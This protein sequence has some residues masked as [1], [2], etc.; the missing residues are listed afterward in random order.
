MSKFHSLKVIDVHK[1][2]DDCKSVA[3]EIPEELKADFA[4]KQGQYLTLRT[5]IEGEDVRRN[6]SLCSSPID[7]E[8]R[9]AIK[10]VPNGKFSTFANEVLKKGDMLDVM[11][12]MGHFY[13]ELDANNKKHYIAFAAG[14]GITPM[15]SIM[16]TVLHTEPESIFTL[17]YGN[18]NTQSIIFHEDIEGLKNKYMTRMSVYYLLSRD[19]LEEPILNGRIDS[20]KCNDLFNGLIDV[21][22]GDE[23]FICG[24]EEMINNVREVLKTAEVSEEKVHFELFTSPDGKLGE[25][26]A[27]EIATEDQGKVCAVTVTV[28]GKTFEF[29]LA[30][31]GENLLDAA[32]KEGADLPYACKGGVCCTCKARLLD[33]EVEMDRN[34]GL[35]EEEVKAGF[36]L[37][38]QAF[39]TSE[40]VAINFDDI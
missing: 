6:Y 3:F 16:K 33:G 17:V 2:V 25:N 4:Y 35:V 37:T 28:D 30:F 9:V 29:P 5:I 34:Y 18:K 26:G 31:G 12:P 15:L 32:M 36:I 38:C 11:P 10:K 24:P 27:R 14:S 39:P 1:E 40:K 19:Q 23:F 22:S 13:T 7:N 20:E 8:W 21:K